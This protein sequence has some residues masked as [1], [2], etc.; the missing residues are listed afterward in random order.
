MR[1]DAELAVE[2]DQFGAVVEL[3]VLQRGGTGGFW[4]FALAARAGFIPPH[5]S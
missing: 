3:A 2:L 5:E 1:G 4:G